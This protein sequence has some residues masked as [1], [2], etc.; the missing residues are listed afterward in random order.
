MVDGD[1][2]SVST[3]GTMAPPKKDW[4]QRWIHKLTQSLQTDENKRMLNVFILDPILNHILDRIFPYIVVMCVLF[5]ILTVMITL[6]LLVVFT[7]LPNAFRE[8]SFL[9]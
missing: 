6:T 9:S 5:V 1:T 4:I 8:S 3:T 7:R 2:R